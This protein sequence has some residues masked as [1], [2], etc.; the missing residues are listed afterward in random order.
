[1]PG[2]IDRVAAANDGDLSSLP[3]SDDFPVGID[4][5][6]APG[7]LRDA[8]GVG[9]TFLNT[10]LKICKDYGVTLPFR[11]RS[12]KSQAL[13]D[14]GTHLP[15]AGGISIKT[16]SNID[17]K[18][19]GFPD[20]YDAEV[21]LVE[22]PIW[23]HPRELN[24]QEKIDDYLN[25]FPELDVPLNEE[26]QN[27]R[28]LV[29]ER[30]KFQLKEW[31]DQLAN[32]QK[33][34]ISGIDADFHAQKQKVGL[35]RYLLPNSGVKRGAQILGK[36]FTD[37]FGKT[38]VAVYRA[39]RRAGLLEHGESFTFYLKDLREKFLNCCSPKLM[40]GAGQKMLAPTPSGRVLTTQYVDNLSIVDGN[41]NAALKVGDDQFAFLAGTLTERFSVSRV[42]TDLTRDLN[43]EVAPLVTASVIARLVQELEATIDRKG[44]VPARVGPDGGPELYEAPDEEEKGLKS[45]AA[46][47]KGYRVPIFRGEASSVKQLAAGET[48]HA[49]EMARILAELVANGYVSEPTESGAQ[50]GR[51]RAAA[52]GEIRTGP[53][54]S[55]VKLAPYTYITVDTTNGST[56][57]PVLGPRALGLRDTSPF[58]AIGDRVVFN[59]GGTSEESTT[60]IG[61]YPLTLNQPLEFDHEIGTTI[62]FLSGLPDASHL[63]G[64]LP[65]K[66]N[67]LVW[68][69]ADA[70]AE[71]DQRHER[72]LMDRS[73][74]K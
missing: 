29:E 15:K 41:P 19:L 2:L 62:L 44:G 39:L 54:G 70:G 55:G 37:R 23:T 14:A 26:S 56:V 40:G 24:Y 16:V 31:P 33:Y 5:R 65:A 49:P 61:L 27:L 63:P 74:A 13:L 12:P 73:I 36:S 58:F 8:Y 66:E 42:A 6:N 28:A 20:E 30:L 4:V 71:P 25:R 51:W 21:A 7:V 32:F 11:S 17:R 60:I 67:L 72:D 1:M 22:P 18:Y 34:E 35:L 9:E 3:D 53:V 45:M 64:A 59:P 10:V 48:K 57:I 46:T 50:G 38:R 43:R 69:R 47:E 68:L 52:P